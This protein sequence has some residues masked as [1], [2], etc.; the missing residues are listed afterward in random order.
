MSSDRVFKRTLSSDTNGQHGATRMSLAY[1]PSLTPAALA[2][3]AE[4]YARMANRAEDRPAG[5][6][7]DAWRKRCNALAREYGALASRD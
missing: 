3:E 1:R 5:F 4:R 6:T 2:R 7:R